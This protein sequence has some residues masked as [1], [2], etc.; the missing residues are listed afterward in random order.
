VAQVAEAVAAV[1]AGR[2]QDYERGWRRASWRYTVLTEG[3]VRA[4]RP[5]WAR[6]AVVPAARVLPK[7]FAGAVHE[8]GRVR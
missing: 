4:T 3:L 5:A 1:E 8:L 2:P 7:V 6:R